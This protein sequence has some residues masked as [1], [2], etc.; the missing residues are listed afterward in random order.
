MTS[1]QIRVDPIQSKFTPEGLVCF[2]SLSSRILH[3]SYGS[4]ARTP[5]PASTA[6]D[7]CSGY[8]VISWSTLLSDYRYYIIPNA[9]VPRLAGVS[10]ESLQLAGPDNVLVRRGDTFSRIPFVIAVRFAVSLVLDT[11]LADEHVCIHHVQA[12]R[13]ELVSGGSVAIARTM[14]SGILA[15]ARATENQNPRDRGN[16][17][18]SIRVDSFPIRLNKRIFVPA[19]TQLTVRVRCDA[20][21]L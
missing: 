4:H 20:I 6:Y 2:L 18:L 10:K 1:A 21:D 15:I 7:M 8:N 16:S 14:P 3:K 11:D 12:R 19:L 5:V 17:I 9:P 13:L